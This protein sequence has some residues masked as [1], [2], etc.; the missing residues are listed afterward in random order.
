MGVRSCT[1]GD[2]KIWIEFDRFFEKAYRITYGSFRVPAGKSSSMKEL[3]FRL[4]IHVVR[5]Y[6][7][8]G[9]FFDPLLFFWRKCSRKFAGYSLSNL[10][11]N[12]K[13][14]SEIPVVAISPDC[15]ITTSVD[16]LSADPNA[17]SVP[18]HRS[19]QY[20]CDA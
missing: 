8:C 15:V 6:I 18:A 4:K 2:R 11:L 7:V 17:V 12:C 13:D 14:I 1:V 10:A 20:V 16:Q 5:L 19:F 3:V 9:F